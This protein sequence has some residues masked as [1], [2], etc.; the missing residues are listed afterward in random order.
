MRARAYTQ[1]HERMLTTISCT[2]EHAPTRTRTHTKYRVSRAN[3]KT[4]SQGAFLQ[5]SLSTRTLTG[6]QPEE[7]GTKHVNACRHTKAHTGPKRIHSGHL[8]EHVMCRECRAHLDACPDKGRVVLHHASTAL[9]HR[10]QREVTCCILRLFVFQSCEMASA[11]CVSC[12]A[13]CRSAL[14]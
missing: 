10:A 12:V 2:R 9:I 7:R 1:T 14:Q 6:L 3:T 13:T 4:S 11:F 5:H 8:L